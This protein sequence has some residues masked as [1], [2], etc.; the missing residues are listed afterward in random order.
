MAGGLVAD[1]AFPLAKAAANV[2]ANVAE[3]IGEGSNLLANA[4]NAGVSVGTKVGNFLTKAAFATA[5]G[6]ASSWAGRGVDVGFDPKKGELLSTTNLVGD[7]V[8]GGLGLVGTFGAYGFGKAIG[9]FG[10]FNML[11]EASSSVPRFVTPFMF[12]T[13]KAWWPFVPYVA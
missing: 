13:K 9:H 8:S 10:W 6:N 7:L 11:P 2:A 5:G 3:D 4:G 12:N 1:A